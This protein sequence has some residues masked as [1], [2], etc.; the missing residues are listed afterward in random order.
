M[1]PTVP[2]IKLFAEKMIRFF[3]LL[4]VVVGLS[5]C[6]KKRTPARHLVHANYEGVVITIYDQAGFP[7]LP[8]KDGYRVYEYPEDGILITS[9]KQEFGWGSDE[10]L[11]VFPDGTHRRISSGNVGGRREHF[12]ASGSQEGGGAPEIEYAFKVIGSVDYWSRVDATEYDRKREE[13]IR[14]LKGPQNDSEQDGADKPATA[15]ESKPE[16]NLNA[17]PEL[18]VRPQ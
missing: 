13:A 12:A 15:L 5:S 10:T 3:T 18:E 16:D 14:K 11:D 4:L 8:M 17:K 9:S 1:S 2:P 6:E 7:A